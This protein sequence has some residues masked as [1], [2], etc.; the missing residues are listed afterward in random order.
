MDLA[1]KSAE[2]F[3]ESV[4]GWGAQQRQATCQRPQQPRQKQSGG[5][6]ALTWERR[7]QA[8]QVP[9]FGFIALAAHRGPHGVA[10]GLQAASREV[11]G[12]QLLSC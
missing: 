1:Q 8:L 9:H 6:P 10:L 12:G 11:G 2:I 5:R 7:R 3:D 4:Q